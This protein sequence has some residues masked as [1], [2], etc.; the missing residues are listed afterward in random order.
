MLRP[1]KWQAE[2]SECRWYAPPGSQDQA[3]RLALRVS[4]YQV[5]AQQMSGG[6]I[7]QYEAFK[8][9]SSL[10]GW[11][12]LIEHMW[13]QTNVAFTL[14]KMLPQARIYVLDPGT[15]DS[16]ILAAQAVDQEQPLAL[17]LYAYG[18]YADLARLRSQHVWDDF[19][20]MVNSVR[21]VNYDPANVT[22]SLPTPPTTAAATPWALPEGFSPEV[23]LPP[24]P[25]VGA[26]GFEQGC[27]NLI[28]LEKADE[29]PLD[30]AIELVSSYFSGDRDK[31]RH[32]SDPAHWDLLITAQVPQEQLAPDWF[33]AP[34]PARQS[35]YAGLLRTQCGQEALDLS[36]TAVYCA[37]PCSQP[38]ISA[39]LMNDFFFV[40]RRGQWLIWFVYP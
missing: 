33:E 24:S 7:A 3:D 37:A 8:Q 36:W 17:G 34:E 19:V 28:G 25:P 18:A 11:T 6:T 22:P 5:L 31:A 39:S 1:E 12:S 13:L 15:G 27:P 23:Y 21:A 10:E 40:R 9:E 35:P 26:T 32:A 29:L 2:A 16:L 4:N 20:T 30:A 14:E 38:G